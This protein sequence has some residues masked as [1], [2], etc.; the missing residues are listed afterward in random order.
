MNTRGHLGV[1]LATG[2]QFLH[3]KY[4]RWV[5]VHLRG[6]RRSVFQNWRQAAARRRHPVEPPEQLLLHRWVGPGVGG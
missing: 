2:Q 5:Q 4:Q 1:S 3:A 6:L